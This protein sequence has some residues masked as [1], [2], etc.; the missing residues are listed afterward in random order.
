MLVAIGSYVTDTQQKLFSPHCKN[1]ST[2]NQGYFYPRACLP[3]STVLHSH[4]C[5]QLATVFKPGQL[6][7]R[8]KQMKSIV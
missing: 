3:H 8:T 7:Y 1:K 4:N 6:K 2:P 5:P